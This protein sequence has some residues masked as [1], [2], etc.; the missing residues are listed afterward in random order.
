[1]PLYQTSPGK[2]IESKVGI[3]DLELIS[4]PN[5][6]FDRH[7][8][9]I[10]AKGNGMIRWI[11]RTFRTCTKEVMFTLFKALAVPSVGCRWII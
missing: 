2:Q 7:I 11:L 8:T 9:D 10:I 1:M 3:G 4:E 5:G 6:K